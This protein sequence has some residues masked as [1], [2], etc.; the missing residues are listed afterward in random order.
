MKTKFVIFFIIL[1]GLLS[2]LSSLVLVK[3]GEAKDTRPAFPVSVTEY[4]SS[5]TLVDQ[6]E[7]GVADYAALYDRKGT[8]QK[9][10][11]D[12]NQD[13]N[14]DDFYIYE[15]GVL[16]RREVDSNFD[17]KIDLWVHIFE[18]SWVEAYE[19]DTNFDGLVDIVK[20]FGQQGP[21]K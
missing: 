1:A 13:G 2:N 5:W 18:G 8:L 10:A 12:Y 11:L 14:M 7:N 20:S 6:S 3:V 16:T 9:E 17:G 4:E 21:K 15:S 19:R